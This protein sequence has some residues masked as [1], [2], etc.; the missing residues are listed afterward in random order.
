MRVAII[1]QGYVGTALGSAASSAGHQVIGIENDPIKLQE[2]SSTLGY[3]VTGDYSK[4]S[5]STILIVA[6]PT[7]L[8]EKREPD[9]SFV[10]SA[11]QSLNAVLDSPA[12]IINESTSFPGTLRNVIAP[13][14][15]SKH[16]YASAPE[17]IDPANE[18]WG[19]ENTPRLVAGLSEE[20]TTKAIEFYGSFCKE[21]IPVSSPEVAEAAKLFENTFRQVNIALVNEFAQI[22]DA[23]GISTVETIK[24][25]SSKPYG[26]MPFMP[27]IGVGGHCIPV[28]P[29]YLSFAAR[30]AGVDASFVDLANKVNALMP[31]YLAAR[32]E[33]LLGGKLAGKK[34]Q[35]A[36]IS[37]KADVSDTRESPALALMAKLR[38]LGADVTWH[39]ERVG[40]CNREKSRRL[41]AVDLG[42]IATAHSGV[43]YSAWKNSLSKVIDL[44]TASNTGW[45]KFL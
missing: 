42:I 21:V 29:S 9:L 26:F 37:Y 2:L 25:A 38:E 6:V 14:L 13:I 39:D 18:T 16:L 28:D 34:I 10:K 1:G 15:G 30:Q 24:A 7:P 22:A 31:E 11:C 43:D 17:R 5:S 19:I 12:L 36:G 32:I 8:D 33:K 4:V 44:S 20:A 3:E 40:A 41:K 27:S 35:I 23:L 45:Q